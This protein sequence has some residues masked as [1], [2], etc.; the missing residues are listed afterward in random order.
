MRSWEAPLTA[1]ATLAVL[2]AGVFALVLLMMGGAHGVI[3]PL[4]GVWLL[5]VVVSGATAACLWS[6]S[7]R[8]VGGEVKSARG[9]RT[10]AILVSVLVSG[11]VAPSAAR[12][13]LRATEG[14][15]RLALITT[16]HIAVAPAQ[17]KAPPAPA[18]GVEAAR[19]PIEEPGGPPA[20]V[21]LACAA[22]DWPFN[23]DFKP[24]GPPCR[25]TPIR[26]ESTSADWF[27]FMAALLLCLI[28]SRSLYNAYQ[29]QYELV[30][31]DASKPAAASRFVI[32]YPQW[33][34]LIVYAAILVPAA[35]LAVGSL[36]LLQTNEVPETPPTL[37][38]ALEV[39]TPAQNERLA[40]LLFEA[41]AGPPEVEGIRA[42]V[43]DK[44]ARIDAE[45]LR[46]VN[47]A[48][49]TFR[50]PQVA[51][52]GQVVQQARQLSRDTL[53]TLL[54][55]CIGVEAPLG[56][57]ASSEVAA[58]RASQSPQP[59]TAPTAAPAEAPPGVSGAGQGAVGTPSQPPAPAAAPGEAG[60][61][62]G[63]PRAGDL[64]PQVTD[65]AQAAA[66]TEAC[67]WIS[68]LVTSGAVAE[69]ASLE[70]RARLWDR[71]PPANPGRV[72]LGLIDRAYPWLGAD[73]GSRPIL[74]MMGLL[75]FGLMGAAIRA[76]AKDEKLID[77]HTVNGDA[78]ATGRAKLNAGQF[79]AIVV[80]GAGAAVAVFLAFQAGALVFSGEP[81]VSPFPQLLFCFLGAVF[82]EEVWAWGR[83]ALRG[84]LDSNGA[85]QNHPAPRRLLAGKIGPASTRT[86]HAA[87]AARER[88]G[89]RQQVPAQEDLAKLA[90][91][92]AE[93][94]QAHAAAESSI[95]A[96][97]L[98]WASFLQSPDDVE[99]AA[100]DEK[101]KAAEA[102]V[103]D[104]VK[105]VDETIPKMT[106]LGSVP[107]TPEMPPNPEPPTPDEPPAPQ[108][109]PAPDQPPAPDEPPGD[110]P[111]EEDRR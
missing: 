67:F 17:A 99:R 8:V 27:V 92:E 73:R 80:Q 28:L 79:G 76:M 98:S 91:M 38:G 64:A 7:S 100:W 29:K 81:T 61:V 12:D 52:H 83:N 57:T 14:V 62:D 74:L 34:A 97:D 59:R 35:Y 93:L 26:W 48:R 43:A 6:L 75:G 19:R 20:A 16:P 87:R 65:Q 32:S 105:L 110:V 89:A 1:L 66:S 18:G 39:L 9:F 86:A 15:A 102:V 104:Y 103:D 58:T 53:A 4:V 41:R 25:A 108:E 50:P 40:V 106:V 46:Q 82:A 54:G 23:R 69:P 47:T 5:I 68:D 37:A 49:G 44:A 36:V 51:D 70:S 94:A 90:A 109:P 101:L 22:Q 30:D 45:Y 85:A 31:E 71:L 10:A 24:L 78:A 107:P 63:T 56:V 96:A 21:L 88:I 60:G 3:W 55:R 42:Q 72:T 13:L 95:R 11:V 33:L 77:E 111:E 2:A 84:F